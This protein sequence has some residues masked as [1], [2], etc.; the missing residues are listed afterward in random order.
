MTHV[1]LD[2][3]VFESYTLLLSAIGSLEFGFLYTTIFVEI[4][5]IVSFA[6]LL[7]LQLVKDKEAKI[8]IKSKFLEWLIFFIIQLAFVPR[9]WLTL[10]LLENSGLA[11]E[12]GS[13]LSIMCFEYHSLV[14]FSLIMISQIL[15]VISLQ[16][17]FYSYQFKMLGW[18]LISSLM[19]SAGSCGMLLCLWRCRMWFFYTVV[20]IVVHNASDFLV[21]HYF[22]LKTPLMVL[23]K[24]ATVE[25]YFAGIISCFLFFTLVSPFQAV[26][27]CLTVKLFD[28]QRLSFWTSHGSCR[29]PP[30]YR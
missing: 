8:V 30:D 3:G 12:R 10:P 1:Q 19:L 28:R 16:E 29:F 7:K 21:C 13:L 25:G 2:V 27:S 6:E 15:F 11:P 20:C 17:G 5:I 26:T 22:P 9:Y 24:E 4:L 23:K 14:I 18:T